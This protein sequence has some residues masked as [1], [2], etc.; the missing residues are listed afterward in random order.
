M[1]IWCVPTCSRRSG[2]N[3]GVGLNNDADSSSSR[4]NNSGLGILRH[5][6]SLITPIFGGHEDHLNN[7]V[8]S[9]LH[10]NDTG[11]F[12]SSCI[13]S[14][15]MASNT[16]LRR[17]NPVKP[18]HCSICNRDFARAEHLQRHTTTRNST[19]CCPS[20]PKLC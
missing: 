20:T 18:F 17:R 15:K 19:L 6:Q 5:L 12:L 10:Q 8:V 2:R 11:S 14:E 9:I 1:I 7:L 16:S 13:A 3:N 4:V